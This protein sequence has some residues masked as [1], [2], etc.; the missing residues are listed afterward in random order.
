MQVN[1]ENW[2]LNDQHGVTMEL[3]LALTENTTP[4]SITVFS[5][6]LR[7]MV[8]LAIEVNRSQLAKEKK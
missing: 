3:K 8:P 6:S 2:V 5:S 7:N 4:G 1:K